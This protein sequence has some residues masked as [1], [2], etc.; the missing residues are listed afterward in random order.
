MRKKNI[1]IQ[2]IS[3]PIVQIMLLSLLITLIFSIYNNKTKIRDRLIS[4]VEFT[5]IYDNPQ[6]NFYLLDIGHNREDDLD[7]SCD[8]NAYI[9]KNDKRCFYEWEQNWKIR[10]ILAEMLDS[11]GISFDFVNSKNIKMSVE[12]K[13]S[14]VNNYH[15][16]N[17]EPI[18][19]FSIHTNFSSDKNLTGFEVYVNKKT[20]TNPIYYNNKYSY[21]R[22]IGELMAE[23]YKAYF[24][25][26]QVRHGITKNVLHKE[27]YYK[28]L[29]D[30]KVYSVYTENEFYSNDKM[31]K[32]IDE[33]AFQEKVANCFFKTIL[34]LENQLYNQIITPEQNE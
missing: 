12:D 20:E 2:L 23:Q 32:I 30:T 16:P 17:G 19:L 11:A 28:I 29:K 5:T 34:E 7:M 6:K 14:Y 13:V 10:D 25:D 4:C 1:I 26:H 24:P 3:R 18:V 31:R 22:L 33:R 27:D 8:D 9:G 21:S 15:T